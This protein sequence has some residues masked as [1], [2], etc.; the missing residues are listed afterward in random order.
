MAQI[1]VVDDEE[2]V[3][4][5]VVRTLE[6]AGHDVVEAADGGTAVEL[7]GRAPSDLVIIDIYMPDKEGLETILELLEKHPDTRI[8][9]MS[10]GHGEFGYAPLST[11]AHLGVAATLA[12]PFSGDQLVATV[13]QA[14]QTS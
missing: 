7:V 1:L 6:R 14:L 4:R 11:A 5:A 3:R 8:V 10:G 9:A 2:Q 13:E 12:K